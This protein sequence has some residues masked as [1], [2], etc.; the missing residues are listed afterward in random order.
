MKFA[1]LGAEPDV[2][3][4]LA[5]IQSTPQHNLVAAYEAQWTDDSDQATSNAFQ[6]GLGTATTDD[7]W[8]SLIVGSVADA[9]I[10]CR[11]RNADQRAEQ[12]RKLT[13][14]G[15][16]LIVVHPVGE[17]VLAFEL[18]MIQQDAGG[19]IVPYQP[20]IDHAVL[21]GLWHAA[22]ADNEVQ[23]L[24]VERRLVDQS[25]ESV[26]QQFARDAMT[27]R[28]LLGQIDQINAIAATQDRDNYHGLSVQMSDERSAV[29]RWALLPAGIGGTKENTATWTVHRAN[30]AS[31]TAVTPADVR[32][33]ALDL[34]PSRQSPEE[35]AREFLQRFAD[36]LQ[37]HASSQPVSRPDW[38]DACRSIELVENIDISRRRKKTISLHY[39][40]ISEENTFK[41]LMAAGGC[42]ILILLT[43][44][45]PAV[46]AIESIVGATRDSGV[47]LSSAEQG[48]D[49]E[50]DRGTGNLRN[51]P[52]S[53]SPFLTTSR[54]TQRHRGWFSRW[55]L[56]LLVLLVVFIGLQFLRFATRSAT[57]ENKNRRS[58]ATQD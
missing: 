12:L 7:M 3:S 31:A 42:V 25:A 22:A 36:D 9:V 52:S 40:D 23:Q 57:T 24:S 46:A 18:L 28:Q 4:L 15:M 20:E 30:G 54:P 44:L 58:P 38:E 29:A 49:A 48:P 21:R 43:L 45:L 6:Q 56:L 50:K 11:G 13:Q 39:E 8:E 5:A 41:S 34:N 2:L 16:P 47:E 32:Q 19:L 14:A 35:A 33:W 26:K 17:A 55:P 27:L 37:R 53:D 51:E 10:V 1:L